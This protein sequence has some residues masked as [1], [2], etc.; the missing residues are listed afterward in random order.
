MNMPYDI[1]SSYG[2]Y[3]FEER[4]IIVERIHDDL[5]ELKTDVFDRVGGDGSVLRSA[6]LGA[7]TITLECRAYRTRW[8]EFDRVK[9][10]MA[11]LLMKDGE[12][13]LSL[14]NHFGEYYLARLVAFEESDRIGGTGIGQFT[15]TFTAFDPI[16]FG[17]RQYV[18]ISG[19]GAVH[20]DVSGS[21]PTTFSVRSSGVS[22][23]GSTGL[24]GLRFDDGDFLYV[25]I[26][27]DGYTPVTLDSYTRQV[28]V[29]GNP[30]IATLDS[31]WPTLEAGTHKV[32]MD[33]GDGSALIEWQERN[34]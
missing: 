27:T 10:E 31:N 14:R 29:A 18:T 26:P 34:V 12:Q 21:Y 2:D 24:W 13:V 32:E 15:L 1:S 8:R 11:Q 7:R 16:R 3:C 22:R 33:M 17:S 9:D 28:R 20:I 5:P 6:H 23:D 30:S 4:D 25:K 19:N